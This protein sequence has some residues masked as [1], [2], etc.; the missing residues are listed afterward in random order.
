MHYPTPLAPPV[1]LRYKGRTRQALKL[2]FEKLDFS[3]CHGNVALIEAKT[4]K[5]TL[6][7]HTDVF[8]LLTFAHDQ[9]EP[10]CLT[11][12]R[13][14]VPKSWLAAKR[15]SLLKPKGHAK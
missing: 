2:Q 1:K 9:L 13:W 3:L 10:A 14:G 4:A 6:K 5:G 7:I 8:T 12:A 15:K 11:V